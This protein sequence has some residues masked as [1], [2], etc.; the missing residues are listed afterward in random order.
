MRDRV[1]D[2]DFLERRIVDALDG[3]AGEDSVGGTACGRTL[4][5]AMKAVKQMAGLE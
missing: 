3:S 4:T 2:E 5:F 1:G